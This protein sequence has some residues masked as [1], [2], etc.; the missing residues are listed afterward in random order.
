MNELMSRS[1][2][3]LSFI[4]TVLEAK[5][6]LIEVQIVILFCIICYISVISQYCVK[7]TI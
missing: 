6:P 3:K 1:G 5:L 4:I 7:K 2:R